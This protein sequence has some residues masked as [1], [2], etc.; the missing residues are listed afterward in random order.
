M[1][2]KDRNNRS[3][4]MLPYSFLPS[5]AAKKLRYAAEKVGSIGNPVKV[6]FCVLFFFYLLIMKW[7]WQHIMYFSN[8][9]KLL[10]HLV[11][12]VL[13][14]STFFHAFIYQTCNLGGEHTTWI[15]LF[16][17]LYYLLF[18]GLRYNKLQNAFHFITW[19]NLNEFDRF[20]SLKS[21]LKLSIL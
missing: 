6:S 4:I 9:L 17:I 16:S 20:L 13:K 10:N 8:I 1:E 2:C 21:A 5:G 18:V 7:F 15:S 19:W 11:C 14:M 12:I 3:A